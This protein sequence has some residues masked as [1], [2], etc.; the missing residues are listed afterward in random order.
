M[1][2][3]VGKP[4]CTVAASAQQKMSK[5]HDNARMIGNVYVMTHALR[6]TADISTAVGTRNC[7]YGSSGAT[8][9]F[10]LML[11]DNGQGDFLLPKQS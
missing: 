7:S 5:L 9:H 2:L 4:Y 3:A 8:F 1:H 11:M 10:T 6:I